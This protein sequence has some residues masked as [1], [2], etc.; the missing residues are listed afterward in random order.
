M[1]IRADVVII[2]GGIVGASIAFHLVLEGFRRIVIVERTHLGAGST[3]RSSGVLRQFYTNKVLVD[4]A[5]IGLDYYSRF[6][7]ITGSP[8]DYTKTGFLL[9]GNE[10]NAETL[11]LGF[12]LQQELGIR[13]RMLAK[14]EIMEYLPSL[15]RTDITLGLYEEDAGYA[16]AHASCLGFIRYAKEHGAAIM[17]GARV[18]AIARDADGV[19]GV[20]TDRDTIET[21]TI[22]NCGGPWAAAIGHLAGMHLPIETSRHYK[23]GIALPSPMDK[24]FPIFSDP[25]RSV[26]IRPD[27]KRLAILGSNHPDDVR[28]KVDP[29]LFRDGDDGG[30]AAELWSRCSD[31][32]SLLQNGEVVGSWSGIYAVTPDGFPILDKSDQV[33]G[34]YSACGLSGHGFKLAPAIGQ[35]VTSLVAHSVPDPRARMFRLSRFEE[36]DL[37]DSVTTSALSRLKHDQP[38]ASEVEQ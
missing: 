32:L 18:L 7:E 28:E 16:D 12:Q 20:R 26:Y 22:I 34:F 6:E 9:A 27:G 36:N 13:S 2:G 38:H 19:S 1:S 24:P 23:V 3:G 17:Q 31:S 4:M 30:K 15:L 21:R 11:G 29:E 37:I 8:S 25:V 14:E 5:R 35:I 10:A 33:K